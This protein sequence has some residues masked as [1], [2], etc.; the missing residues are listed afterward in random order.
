MK[1]TA[2]VIVLVCVGCSSGER[3]LAVSPAP[4]LLSSTPLPE[5]PATVSPLGL[6]LNAQFTILPD[7]SVSAVSLL[8]SSGSPAWDSLALV[9]MREWRFSRGAG[10]GGGTDRVVRYPVVVQPGIR[11]PAVMR[12]GE[13]PAATEHEAD[14]LYA[15][16]KNGADFDA[17][18]LEASRRSAPGRDGY[19]RTV[20][21]ASL[22]REVRDHVR[23]LRED[24]ISPPVRMDTA[25]VIFRRYPPEESRRVQ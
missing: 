20:D 6:K 17:L 15:L 14:S 9:A 13:L 23:C 5:L 1:L 11:E 24:E 10:T 19:I 3:T 21:L 4:H 2:L 7:G 25:Y 8:T 16:L 22:S 18:A 12:L